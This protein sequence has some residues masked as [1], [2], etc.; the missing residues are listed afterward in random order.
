M[1]LYIILPTWLMVPYLIP[2][3]TISYEHIL[4]ILFSIKIVLTLI[5]TIFAMLLS[6]LPGY[7]C[8]CVAIPIFIMGI[9][10]IIIALI[11]WAVIIVMILFLVILLGIVLVIGIVM[12]MGGGVSTG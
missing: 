11:I 4:I 8:I 3:L 9:F 7:G 5:W 6:G 2:P 12:V 1:A 10:V